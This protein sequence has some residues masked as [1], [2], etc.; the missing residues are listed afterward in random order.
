M[1]QL[2]HLNVEHRLTYVHLHAGQLIV[3]GLDACLIAVLLQ[4]VHE[5]LLNVAVILNT[6]FRVRCRMLQYQRFHSL[7]RAHKVLL[8][9]HVFRHEA[10]GAG[11]TDFTRRWLLTE[12]ALLPVQQI[13][14]PVV[15]QLI[16][17]LR[18]LLVVDSG[19]AVHK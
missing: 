8:P 6:D 16:E 5:Q 3:A 19:N 13:E 4:E 11:F 2:A 9:L 7:R 10:L 14:V 17:A 15:R 18:P 12:A 1:L